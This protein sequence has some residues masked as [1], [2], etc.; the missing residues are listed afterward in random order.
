MGYSKNH[1]SDTCRAYIPRTNSVIISRDIR[2]LGKLLKKADE[3]VNELPLYLTKED[4]AEYDSDDS[5]TYGDIPDLIQ[6]IDDDNSDDE[7]K[8]EKLKN[9]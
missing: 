7:S 8:E 9:S 6:R 3:E 4:T 1:S 2:W 5:D